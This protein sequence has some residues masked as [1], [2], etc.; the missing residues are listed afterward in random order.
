MWFSKKRKVAS[1]SRSRKLYFDQL[2]DRTLLS[3]TYPVDPSAITVDGGNLTANFISVENLTIESD[4]TINLIQLT[5]NPVENISIKNA[6]NNG[7]LN[8]TGGDKTI[9][10]IFGTGNLIVSGTLTATSICQNT[11]TIGAGSKVVIAPIPVGPPAGITPDPAGMLATMDGGILTYNS[12]ALPNLS[13]VNTPTLVC[14]DPPDLKNAWR[15][16]ETI[17]GGDTVLFPYVSSVNGSIVSR[18]D[19]APP[20]SDTDTEHETPTELTIYRNRFGEMIAGEQDYQSV[21]WN[22]TATSRTTFM[23]NNFIDAITNTTYGS[24]SIDSIVPGTAELVVSTSSQGSTAESTINVD[25]FPDRTITRNEAQQLEITNRIIPTEYE[26]IYLYQNVYSAADVTLYDDIVYILDEPP[27]ESLNGN[28]AQAGEPTNPVRARFHTTKGTNP[29]SAAGADISG[30]CATGDFGQPAGD[31]S[32]YDEDLKKVKI[33]QEGGPVGTHQVVV[34]LFGTNG[35][36]CNTVGGSKSGGEIQAWAT[37]MAPGSEHDIEYE[38]TVSVIFT[39]ADPSRPGLG[40]TPSGGLSGIRIVKGNNPDPPYT[41]SGTSV[42][43]T[44]PIPDGKMKKVNYSWDGYVTVTADSKGEAKVVRVEPLC[45][46]NRGPGLVIYVCTIIVRHDEWQPTQFCAQ[47]NLIWPVNTLS[48]SLIQNESSKPK[49]TFQMESVASIKLVAYKFVT[50]NKV[51]NLFDPIFESDILAADIQI[52]S[53]N[54]KTEKISS[55]D[56]IRGVDLVL[57]RSL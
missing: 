35:Y 50:V 30:G 11:L 17:V 13:T 18:G 27:L 22:E 4:A 15:S 32:G 14:T 37:G 48:Q 29:Y 31:A 42:S 26:Y 40:G 7:A 5:G 25:E 20:H 51:D 33:G 53:N 49:T 44:N 28:Y 10:P 55:D 9:G 52:R 38:V 23:G 16:T 6:I 39:S 34:M 46:V 24:G 1:I 19:P 54:S 56:W 41:F 45:L 57:D 36:T 2:E 47:T 12:D 3:L 21:A 43:S 8:V